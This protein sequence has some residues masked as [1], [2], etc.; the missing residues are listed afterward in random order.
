MDNLFWL[1]LIAIFTYIVFDFIMY[2]IL[3]FIFKRNY[4]NYIEYVKC[5]FDLSKKKDNVISLK[6]NDD[7][8][9]A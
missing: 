8:D 1:S 6:G 5:G 3:K 9:N 2:L 4:K 7:N